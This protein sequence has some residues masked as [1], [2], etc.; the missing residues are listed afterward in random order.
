[1][2]PFRRKFTVPIVTIHSQWLRL[3]PMSPAVTVKPTMGELFRAPWQMKMRIN[4]TVVSND[5]VTFPIQRHLIIYITVQIWNQKKWS[6]WFFNDML[7]YLAALERIPQK[8]Q[9][10]K[11]R[12]GNI[13]R[14]IIAYCLRITSLQWPSPL[15]TEKLSTTWIPALTR[16]EWRGVFNL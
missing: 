7:F 10:I 11:I 15:M 14:K 6:S 9:H 16:F 2:S 1:M 8:F 3:T 5:N 13:K 4:T 12:W